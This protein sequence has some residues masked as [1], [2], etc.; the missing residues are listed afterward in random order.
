MIV[1]IKANIFLVLKGVTVASSCDWMECSAALLRPASW[2]SVQ[3]SGPIKDFYVIG[4]V[5]HVNESRDD[6][7]RRRDC[8]CIS[9]QGLCPN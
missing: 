1:T 4:L 9:I 8:G 3:D 7:A 5:C 2:R 6:Y